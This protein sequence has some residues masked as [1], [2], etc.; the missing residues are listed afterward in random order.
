[1]D[2]I[3]EDFVEL[4]FCEV[5]ENWNLRFFYILLSFLKYG[6]KCRI[7]ASLTIADFSCGKLALWLYIW[8]YTVHYSIA[9]P[10]VSDGIASLASMRCLV[11]APDRIESR[12]AVRVY[13]G[14]VESGGVSP[15]NSA[16]NKKTQPDPTLSNP[17]R[18]VS[19]TAIFVK[20]SMQVKWI[21]DRADLAGRN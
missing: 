7:F 4:F 1:M 13:R 21:L 20:R 2:N 9:F 8:L 10:V 19:A 11:C 14:G 3:V 6:Q 5:F 15:E 17:C 12:E 16:Q 18:M